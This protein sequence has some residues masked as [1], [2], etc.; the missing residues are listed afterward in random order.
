MSNPD[1]N[2]QVFRQAHNLITQFTQ[3]LDY[4]DGKVRNLEQQVETLSKNKLQKHETEK[5][6]KSLEPKK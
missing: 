4:Y 3:I 5:V 2:N 6:P 1:Q